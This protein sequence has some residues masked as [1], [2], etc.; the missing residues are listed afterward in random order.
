[1]ES[2]DPRPGDGRIVE[3]RRHDRRAKRERR[4]GWRG[5]GFGL[6]TS[7]ARGIC[8]ATAAEAST[9]IGSNDERT[10]SALRARR[11]AR[12]TARTSATRPGASAFSSTFTIPP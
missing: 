6:R 11:T 8:G 10:T 1:M 12:T 9:T 4:A 3:V 7:I 5:A 2:L